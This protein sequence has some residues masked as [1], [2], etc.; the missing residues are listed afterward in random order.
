MTRHEETLRYE[1]FEGNYNRQLLFHGSSIQNFVS[2]LTNGL[3]IRP[4]EAH[5]HGSLFGKGIYFSDAASKAASYCGGYVGGTGLLL[6]CEVAAGYA[7]IRYHH[8][9][10]KLID[11]CESLQALGKYY[12]HPMHI[13]PDG[14]KIPNG[15]L[16]QRPEQTGSIAFNEFVVSDPARVKIRYLVKLKFNQA[17]SRS[18][19]NNISTLPILKIPPK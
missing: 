2:I 4:P 10:S 16:I 7:D 8:D 13:R 12:P 9:H 18:T 19:I 6:L 1:P 15:T 14:L 3:K 5:H 11:Y 17:L